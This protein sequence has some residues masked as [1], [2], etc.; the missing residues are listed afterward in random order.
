M[1]IRDEIVQKRR[2]CIAERGFAL[3]CPV[4]EKRNLPVAR[5][6]RSPF[7]ICEVKRSSPSKGDIARHK[8]PVQQAGVYAGKGV[9]T[10]SVLTEPNY[11]SGSLGDLINIKRAYPDLAVLR[12]DFL[13]E[14]EDI[15]ISHRAGADAI[16]LI[17]S[18]LS[19]KQLHVLYTEARELGLAVLLEVHD[20]ADIKKAADLKPRFTGINSRDLSTFKVDLTLPL[21]IKRGITWDTHLVFESGIWSKE[22][23]LFALSSG[24]SALLVGEAVMRDPECIAEIQASYSLKAGSFWEKLY[25]RKQQGRPLVKICGITRAEDAERAA[26]LGADALGF[27]FAPSPRQAD[28]SLLYK[29]KDLDI[30]K[31]G[32]VVCKAHADIDPQV[33]KLLKE[34]YLDAVQFHGDEQPAACFAAAFPYYKAVQLRTK[35]DVDALTGY[36]CPRVLIDAYAEA[37]RGGTGHRLSEELIFRTKEHTALWLAGGLGPHNIHEIITRF[38][39]ELID[40]SSKL[41]A[42]PGKK[43]SEKLTHYFKEI[44]RAQVL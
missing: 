27:I 20:D 17:A 21:L 40:A 5:F 13:L 15:H 22:D 23:A 44:E 7:L 41:E 29:L 36:R 25:S 1:N 10:V 9:K 34:Q 26:R 8:D 6:D 14:K 18:I 2:K 31:V 4:P 32:V 39:P 37:A 19:K 42:E 12:K 16:L 35:G 24:F 33:S 43:D 11:F 28:I 38:N 30:L 3:G